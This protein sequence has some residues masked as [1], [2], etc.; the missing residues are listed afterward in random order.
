MGCAGSGPALPAGALGGKLT[1]LDRPAPG[2][3]TSLLAR[4]GDAWVDATGADGSPLTAQADGAG[5]YY[6]PALPG[7]TYRVVYLAQEVPDG[8]GAPLP[9]REVAAWNSADVTHRTGG[10]STVPDIEVTYN[11]LIYPDTG[12]SYPVATELPLPFH[13]ATHRH[14]RR[15]RLIVYGNREGRPPAFYQGPWTETPSA[16]LAQEA[17]P[18]LYAWEVFIDGGPNGEGRSGRRNLDLKPPAQADPPAGEPAPEP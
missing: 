10:T 3:R 16:V 18:D 5:V 15:Y 8:N 1:Y 2:K 14:G 12:Q 11:G 13:W 17:Q 9:S 7:G 6:F 4:K